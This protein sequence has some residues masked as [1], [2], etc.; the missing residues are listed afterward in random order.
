MTGIGYALLEEVSVIYRQNEKGFGNR[1][2]TFSEFPVKKISKL[3]FNLSDFA[4]FASIL[5]VV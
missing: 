1:L 4:I 2:Y 5:S 3:V